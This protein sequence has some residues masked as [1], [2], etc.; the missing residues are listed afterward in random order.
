MG[1][2]RSD[3]SI[4][5]D[6]SSPVPLYYQVAR[7]L[8][9]AIA[10]GRVE[11]GGFLGNEIELS[12]AW[13]ISRPTVR[14]AIQELVDNGILVRQR[15]VGTQ[16]VNDAVRPTS[17][18]TS[19][20]DELVSAGRTPTSTVLALEE[21]PGDAWVT[22]E[23]GLPPGSN[24]LYVE[25]CRLAGNRRLAIIR[26]WAFLGSVR[27]LTVEVLNSG[28]MYAYLRSQGIWPHYAT[29]QIGARNA[30]PV[31]AALLG[32]P[33]GAAVLTVRSTMQDRSGIKVDVT[34][35]ICDASSYKLDLTVIE[36]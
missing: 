24:V 2:L 17:R 35:M 33:V 15:G 1:K 6:K 31:D 3:F 30:S 7:E 36:T 29:Q 14:R 18:V 23:L 26:N 19:L 8:E 4:E 27:G 25:R 20:Y 32:L 16:V 21:I 9:K 11:R 28:G 22:K 12:E 34:E 10:D 5:I 13:Q